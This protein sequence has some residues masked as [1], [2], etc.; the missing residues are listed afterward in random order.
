MQK[1]RETPRISANK[2]GEYLVTTSASRRRT[3][4]TDQKHPPDVKVIRYR[5]ARPAIA[6]FIAGCQS[7]PAM[8]EG[9]M[10][11]LRMK[12]PPS[13]FAQQDIALSIEAMK[14]ALSLSKVVE[15]EGVKLSLAPLDI[16]PLLISGVEV[17]VYPEVLV[18]GI[19][20]KGEPIVG[21][22]KL[23]LTKTIPHATTSAG[24]V[25]TLLHWMVEEH[26]A[27]RGEPAASLCRVVDIHTAIVHPC[28]AAMK[29]RKNQIADACQ[30]IADRWPNL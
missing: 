19:G 22:I 21:A 8:I 15:A 12:N 26:L 24:Y 10:D 13:D 14:A 4:I 5:D 16:E 30:E 1:T 20:K 29:Q 2:L 28:P 6:R 17:S 18:E 9:P 11:L 7:D 27:D 3:I 25:N 23:N